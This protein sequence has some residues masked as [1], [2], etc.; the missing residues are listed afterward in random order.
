[1]IPAVLSTLPQSRID[2]LIALASKQCACDNSDFNTL[3]YGG[4]NYDDCYQMGCED[5]EKVLAREILNELK[6]DYKKP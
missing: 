5:G 1:M 3:D 4:G 2:S 6:I